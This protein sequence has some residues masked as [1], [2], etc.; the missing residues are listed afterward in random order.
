M[1]VWLRHFLGWLRSAFCAREDLILDTPC[2]ASA[3]G[4]SP[5]PTASPTTHHFAEAV[6]GRT[7]KAMGSMERT[8]HPGHTQNRRRLASCWIPAVL[9]LAFKS[10]VEG[11]AQACEQRN[12]SLDFSNGCKESNV[13][14]TAHSRRAAQ[15]RLRSI[16]TDGLAMASASAQEPRCVQALAS[17]LAE[18]S[19]GHRGDGLFHCADTH[20]RRPLLL[21]H[22]RS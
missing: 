6:L 11:R 10:P 15:T 2:S 19:R 7:A 8:S 9:E 4:S 17:V 16:G 13:G 20:L 3:V 12:S 18:P 22:H 5:R 14:S 1:I 21:L